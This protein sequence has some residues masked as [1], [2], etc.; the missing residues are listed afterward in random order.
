[1]RD[2]G[3]L[4]PDE[5]ST[6]GRSYA[7]GDRVVVTRNDHRLGIVNGQRGVV[8]SVEDDALVLAVDGSR[9]VSIPGAR[10]RAGGLDHGYALTA[11]RAQGA[12]VDRA[13]VLGSDELY[14]EWGYT[15]LSRHR[16]SARFYI[17]ATPAFLNAAGPAL[18]AGPDATRIVRHMLE[19][20][21]AQDLAVARP[22]RDPL[23]AFMRAPERPREIG[24]RR[25][26]GMERER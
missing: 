16:E 24:R 5:L 15:A 1:M 22:A 23:E 26:L 11:H 4:G 8:T 10:L 2:A 6:A 3:R 21:R 20:S 19:T 18:E 14:R 12:T 7:V 17:S 25:D 9:A 13:F